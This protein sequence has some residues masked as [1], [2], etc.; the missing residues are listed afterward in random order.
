ML[1]MMRDTIGKCQ[2]VL[3]SDEA[4]LSDEVVLFDKN[5]KKSVMPPFVIL[6]K[7]P[8]KTFSDLIDNVDED[9]EQKKWEGKMKNMKV[10][11]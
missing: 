9:Q 1:E 3:N 4:S 2:D 8:I 6:E 5:D 10:W 11:S 7:S